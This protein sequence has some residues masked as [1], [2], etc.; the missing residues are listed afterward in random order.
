M[1]M[2]L[3]KSKKKKNISELPNREDNVVE[4]L[5]KNKY[6]FIN[7]LQLKYFNFSG[8]DILNL[9]SDVY[10]EFNSQILLLQI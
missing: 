6:I 9:F 5:V 3:I 8:I 2:V 7:K 10:L 1:T 4:Y